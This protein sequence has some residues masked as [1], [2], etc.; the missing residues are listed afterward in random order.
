MHTDVGLWAGGLQSVVHVDVRL[1]RPF[2]NGVFAID[3]L[4]FELSDENEQGVW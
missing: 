1:W 3:V 4:I 2:L